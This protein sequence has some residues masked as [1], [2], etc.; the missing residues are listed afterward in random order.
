M[1]GAEHEL[2]EYAA[3]NRARVET[4]EAELTRLRD[5]QHDLSAEVAAMRYL[6]EA[7]GRLATQVGEVAKQVQA[8]SRRA[9]EKPSPSVMSAYA[10]WAAVAVAV[11]ALVI[12]ATR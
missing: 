10:S 5:R 7:V 3:S 12:A 8:V 2:W 6:G 9:V 1:P 4:I 11:V